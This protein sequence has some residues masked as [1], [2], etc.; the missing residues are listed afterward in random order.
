MGSS[1]NAARWNKK[2]SSSG[3]K[4]LPKK[5]S[6]LA[7]RVKSSGT[8]HDNR[9]VRLWDA[10]SLDVRHKDYLPPTSEHYYWALLTHC[11]VMVEAAY[12]GFAKAEGFEPFV[13]KHKTGS[14]WWLQHP[15]TG[16]ILDPSWPQHAA[17][18]Q[19]EL[20]HKQNLVPPSPSKRA[21]EIMRRAARKSRGDY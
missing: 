12:H 7:A 18:Y 8:H 21:R 10:L 20:G 9:L 19:Y 17:P 3:K 15:R 2:T 14:H 5:P 16:R 11:Y 1:R 6:A 13:H 4:K